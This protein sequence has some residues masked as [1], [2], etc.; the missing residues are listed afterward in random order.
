LFIPSGVLF[1]LELTGE[2]IT[3]EA[4]GRVAIEAVCLCVI[5]AAKYEGCIY[6]G[7]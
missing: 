3:L 1:Y 7:T 6:R 4:D 5:V 2:W